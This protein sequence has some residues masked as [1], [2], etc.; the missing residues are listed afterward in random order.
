M[1]TLNEKISYMKSEF[2]LVE[3]KFNG[4][5]WQRVERNM[6]EYA[7]E[8]AKEALRLASENA[9]VMTKNIDT[10][11]ELEVLSWTDSRNVKFSVSKQ[12]ILSENNLPKHR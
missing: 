1:K 11:N 3:A 10:E 6:Q 9:R 7:T 4:V 8:Y 2:D 5:T 12:S